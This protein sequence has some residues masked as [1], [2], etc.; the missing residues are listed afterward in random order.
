MASLTA[1]AITSVLLVR[2]K[3]DESKR[4]YSLRRVCALRSIV[5]IVRTDSTGYLPLADSPESIVASVPSITALKTSDTSERVARGFSVIVSS[6]FVAVITAL[7]AAFTLVIIIFW[8]TGTISNGT[9]IPMSPR[10]IMI[11]SAASMI[12]SRLSIPCWFSILA[13]NCTWSLPVS[14]QISRTSSTSLA[15]RT[16]EIA[17]KLSPCSRPKR[18]SALSRS[19]SAGKGILV[20][21]ILTPFCLAI[22]P[23]FSTSTIN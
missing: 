3:A 12:S 5:A 18:I 22:I 10:A 23:S 19:A 9:S 7:P 15:V 13:N 11:P 14:R 20:L 6:M 1:E 4:P 16:N 21:G 8:K 17:I 2:G